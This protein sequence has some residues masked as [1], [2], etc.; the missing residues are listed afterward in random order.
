MVLK[1]A[2]IPIV[3]LVPLAACEPPGGSDE[4]ANSP[5]RG[6]IVETGSERPRFT[7]SDT[8]GNP[9]SFEDETDG[10]LAFIFFGYTN[11]PDVCPIHMATL[12]SSIERLDPADRGRV[13][14]VFISTDPLRDTPDV[15]R[16]WLDSFDPGFVGLR[17]TVDEVNAVA[18]SLLLPPAA[19]PVGAGDSYTVGHAASVLAVTPDG[20]TRVK[21]GFG[22]RQED[23]ATDLPLLL[24]WKAQA[25]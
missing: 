8:H 21:Y 4:M 7:L 16:R 24:Q 13:R 15:L 6:S 5:L 25:P 17:G 22:T 20:G 10:L 9:Y 1:R 23:W 18:E 3:L 12:A 14:V 19:V 2:L 11:C